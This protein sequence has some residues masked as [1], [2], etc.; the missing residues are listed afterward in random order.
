MTNFEELRSIIGKDLHVKLKKLNE[1]GYGTITLN[2][3]WQLGLTRRVFQIADEYRT[4]PLSKEKGRYTLIYSQ[5]NQ[6]L[7]YPNIHEY[8]A[9]LRTF[10]NKNGFTINSFDFIYV[11]DEL[12]KCL[13]IIWENESENNK[14]RMGD[15]F[16]R[17][18][19]SDKY[20]EATRY[21]NLKFI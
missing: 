10:C 4:N 14:Y 1:E 11:W 12:E 2:W 18:W 7:I 13:V 16:A 19:F 6:D 17:F 9:Y 15:E 3:E 8:M 5:N 21:N 20:D